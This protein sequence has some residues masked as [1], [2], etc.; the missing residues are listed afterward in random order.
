MDIKNA[1]KVYRGEGIR[2]ITAKVIGIIYQR[3]DVYFSLIN[4]EFR[5]CPKTDLKFISLSPE[6]LAEMVKQY[7]S[8]LRDETWQRLAGRLEPDSTERV[9]LVTGT[10]NDIMGFYCIK[11][12]EFFDEN[13]GYL[14][15]SRDGNMYLYDAYTF[16]KHRGK[17][18]QKFA[19]LALLEEG[20]KL[21]FKTATVMVNSANKHSEISVLKAGFKKCGAVHHLKFL[22]FRANIYKGSNIFKNN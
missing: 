15:P 2:G 11:N 3:T 9:Y 5:P 17:G 21:G 13:T 6:R 7:C 12:G 14:F 8:E 4:V 16:I 10:D 1:L 22:T 18:S 19:T 20:Q